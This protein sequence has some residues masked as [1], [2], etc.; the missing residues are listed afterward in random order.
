MMRVRP[1]CGWG[2]CFVRMVSSPGSG[3]EHP[4]APAVGK[5]ALLIGQ[6]GRRALVDY[7][8]GTGSIPAGGS[9]H[10]ELYSGAFLSFEQ[11]AFVDYLARLR[12]SRCRLRGAWRRHRPGA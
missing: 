1:G 8:L 10:A 3:V 12:S 2:A 6:S 11:A 5:T 4:F 7:L 9:V